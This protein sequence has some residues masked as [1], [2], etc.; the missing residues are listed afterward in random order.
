MQIPI[1]PGYNLQSVV[2]NFLCFMQDFSISLLIAAYICLTNR[3]SK[4]AMWPTRLAGPTCQRDTV[5]L[6]TPSPPF[7]SRL[8]ATWLMSDLMVF[9]FHEEANFISF[10]FLSWHLLCLVTWKS[11]ILSP[12]QARYYST[13]GEEWNLIMHGSSLP[14]IQPYQSVLFFMWSYVSVICMLLVI[15]WGEKKKR[16]CSSQWWE[17]TLM[18]ISTMH[19]LYSLQMMGL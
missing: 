12:H 17:N 16:S 7:A 1:K 13:L 11:V 15:V 19:L 6:T 4:P 8:L 14:F 2:L 3:P 9:C 18:G 5:Q 10:F